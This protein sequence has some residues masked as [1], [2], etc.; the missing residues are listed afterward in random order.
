[1]DPRAAQTRSLLHCAVLELAAEQPLDD[2]AVTRLTALAGVNR[3]SFYQHFRSVEE[4]LASA[5]ETSADSAGRL[6]G[7]VEAT[8][9]NTPPRELT[10]FLTHFA[11]HAS[12]YRRA[13]G[14]EGS[15]LVAARVRARVVDLV[16]EGIE[17]SE[18]RLTD[19]PLDIEAAGTAGAL[20]GAIEA[21]LHRDPLPPPETAAK[22]LWRILIHDSAD[23]TTR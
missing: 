21:W 23:L 4:L 3:S 11:E 19:L 18:R 13:L 15:A 16:L 9:L 10:R 8:D 2:I 1:M 5:L 6:T 22:W 17:I 7:P 20:L 12:I 14:S